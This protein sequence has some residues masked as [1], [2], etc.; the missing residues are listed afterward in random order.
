MKITAPNYTQTPNDL[1]DYWLPHLKEGELKVLLVIMRKTFG[2]HKKRDRI[3]ISQLMRLTGLSKPSVIDA[4]KSLQD[5]GIILRD[6]TGEEG[7]QETY[8]ELIVNEDSNNSYPVK[9]IDP[10]SQN[11][12]PPP[13]VKNSDTQK[14]PLSSKETAAAKKEKTAAVSSDKQILDCLRGHEIPI[15]DILEIQ[16]RYSI[17]VIENAVAWAIHKSNP[18]KKCL[19]ASIKYACKHGLSPDE[20][21]KK[22][23]TPKD[24]VK[25]IFKN[26]EFYNKAECFI[27]DDCISFQRGM[28]QDQINI[29]KFFK[30][31]N[32]IVLCNK[33][34]IEIS[35]EK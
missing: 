19:S 15:P 16:E 4:S 18:P 34:G 5:K 13:P 12:C 7:E 26:G 20:F 2:W 3:S 25:S 31:E 32:L 17:Q 10:P 29:D 9:I 8:Y 28:K 22:K 35:E 33:F 14:K 6:K 23:I 1:F 27:T 11:Y 24:K 21:N 30:W